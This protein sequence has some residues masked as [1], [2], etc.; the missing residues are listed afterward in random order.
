MASSCMP[1]GCRTDVRTSPIPVWED[2][3][4]RPTKRTS[5]GRAQ[6][7][8]ACVRP[9]S[10]TKA[11]RRIIPGNRMSLHEFGSVGGRLGPDQVGGLEE[12]RAAGGALPAANPV[13]AVVRPQVEHGAGM[14]AVAGRAI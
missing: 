5:V 13:E 1:C 10:I 6:W 3:F 4:A 11:D 8:Y 7:V 9:R 12:E 14:T 2:P